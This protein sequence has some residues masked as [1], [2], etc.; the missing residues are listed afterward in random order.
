M[1]DAVKENLSTSEQLQSNVIEEKL[2]ELI[3]LESL[4][5]AIETY[6]QDDARAVSLVSRS[7][8]SELTQEE[9]EKLISIVQEAVDAQGAIIAEEVLPAG[10]I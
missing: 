5:S 9:I 6:L 3:D 7:A 2:E 10:M 8:D 4:S 1:Y